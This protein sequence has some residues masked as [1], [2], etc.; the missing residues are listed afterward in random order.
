MP[1][2][3]RSTSRSTLSGSTLSEAGGTGGH[4]PTTPLQGP[5]HGLL[6]PLRTNQMAD[7][8]STVRPGKGKGSQCATIP[9]P[10]K[11][12]PMGGPASVP[13]QQ[14]ESGADDDREE[15][16]LS[17]RDLPQ[18]S[19]QQQQRQAVETAA[20]PTVSALTQTEFFALYK[21]FDPKM[22]TVLQGSDNFQTWDTELRSVCEDIQT[23]F[24]LD[25]GDADV[26]G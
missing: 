21:L 13:S 1:A 16:D 6:T 11:I 9:I 2:S 17:T 10:M 15:N 3:T 22:T 26:D 20:R 12:N 14:L 19:Y 8:L 4:T 18:E 5:G 24:I 23:L 7:G 25:N